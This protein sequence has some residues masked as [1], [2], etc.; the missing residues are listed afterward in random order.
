VLVNLHVVQ[1]MFK[2]GP[3]LNMIEIVGCCKEIKRG[4]VGGLN[5]LLPGAKVVTIAQIISTQQK[6]NE[7]VENFAVIFLIIIVVVGVVSIAN[8][9]S[10]NV[11]ERRKEIGTLLAIGATP[12]RILWIFIMKALLLGVSGGVLGY[13][14]GTGV[15]LVLGPR[16]ANIP[17][18][19]LP[20]L[21]AWALGIAVGIAVLASFFPA[22][23][24]ART[25]PALTTQ[26]I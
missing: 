23:K 8:Y 2:T 15:A 21:I 14:I 6:T 5:N 18:K 17:V 13:V 22:L 3:V 12:A 9:M 1:E 25:D 24:A 26:E 4:L 7:L 16:L 19:P 11:Y 20:I 10:S